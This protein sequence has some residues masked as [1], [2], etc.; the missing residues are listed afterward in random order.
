MR[1]LVAATSILGVISVICLSVFWRPA[2]RAIGISQ[3][4]HWLIDEGYS[5]EEIAKHP[6]IER[7]TRGDFRFPPDAVPPDPDDWNKRDAQFILAVLA[8]LR[9]EYE[10]LGER[11]EASIA[12]SEEWD[13][14]RAPLVKEITETEAAIAALEEEM[15]R[16]GLRR[17]AREFL[18]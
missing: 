8:V 1:I 3:T 15:Q 16:L 17:I 13:R 10:E 11:V 4:I 12:R 18:H 14:Q 6:E 9:Q 7:L 5:P 2:I